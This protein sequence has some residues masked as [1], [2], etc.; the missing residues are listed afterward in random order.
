MADYKHADHGVIRYSDQ[1]FVPKDFGN[2][3]WIAYVR[4]VE[5]GGL[6]D[7]Q[8]T[9]EELEDKEARRLRREERETERRRDPLEGKSVRQIERWLDRKFENANSISEVKDVTK[10]ILKKILVEI[11]S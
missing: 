9:E 7:P 1:A 11:I 10:L 4:Y 8:F 6:T 2:R 5:D 3:D